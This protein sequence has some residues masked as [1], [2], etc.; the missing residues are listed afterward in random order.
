MV[1]YLLF[2]H[3][4]FILITFIINVLKKGLP[5]SIP[6]PVFI[7]S[8]LHPAWDSSVASFLRGTFTAIYDLVSRPLALS[9]TLSFLT[10][11]HVCAT[12]SCLY[13]RHLLTSLPLH[14]LFLPERSLPTL[15]LTNP[16]HTL[17]FSSSAPPPGSLP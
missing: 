14:M 1:S 6:V 12:L 11:H 17:R 16:Q 7:R 10:S 8:R 3:L 2:H 13:S 4:L 15:V 5:P 9:L